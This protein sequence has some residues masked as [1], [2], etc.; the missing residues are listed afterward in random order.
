MFPAVPTI[1]RCLMI[2]TI[3]RH[4]GRFDSQSLR[5]DNAWLATRA[6]Q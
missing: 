3:V 5:Q 6:N 4:I 1:L 2:A